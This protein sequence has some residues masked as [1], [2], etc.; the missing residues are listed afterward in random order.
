VAALLWPACWRVGAGAGAPDSGTGA[1]TDADA[2]EDTDTDTDADSDTDSDSDTDADTD[3]DS[4]E[5][6][7]EVSWEAAETGYEPVNVLV[8]LDR[9]YSMW[10]Y[11]HGIQPYAEITAAALG[12]VVIEYE[13]TGLVNFGLTGFP[14]MSCLAGDIGDVNQCTPANDE[15]PEPEHDAPI[16][17]VGA[18]NADEILAALDS[19]GQ[20]GGTPLCGSMEWALAYLSSGLPEEVAGLKTHVLIATVGAPNCNLDLD[21]GSCEPSEEDADVYFPEQCLDDVCSYGAAL[22]LA[23]AGI[24]VFIVG[25]GGWLDYFEDVMQGIAYYG[26]GG[27][28]PPEEIPAD[29]TLWYPATD[30]ES[31]QA[32]F[33]EIIGQTVPC[34][35]TMPWDE[36]PYVCPDPPYESVA[37][38]CD[39]VWVIGLV[40]D[41]SDE[42]HLVYSPD[43]A[44]E[45]SEAEMYSWRWQGLDEGDD[46][47]LEECTRIELCPEACAKLADGSWS[48]IA[49]RLP[50][51][52][53]LDN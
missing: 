47:W 35:L 36:I 33:D 31:L 49:A 9:S 37:K 42:I 6:C 29:P 27:L 12:N 48:G 15:E 39:D 18:G 53:L 41:T 25:L 8:L 26:S 7:V 13:A 17:E 3:T 16:V 32:A 4:Y 1:D 5:Y 21:I 23:A 14:S 2:D 28:L 38:G 44:Y 46:Y 10:S 34:T 40:A 22:E 19:I 24:G 50:L 51:E 20:C 11:H 52:I 30:A 45:D 43:C